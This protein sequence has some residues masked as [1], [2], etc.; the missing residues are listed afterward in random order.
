MGISKVVPAKTSKE[1][2]Q[3]MKHLL[4]DISALE[5]MLD[6]N[7]FEDDITRIGA[8]QEFFLVDKHWRPAPVAPE[9][10]KKLPEKYFT[11]ELAKFNLE[12]NLDPQLFDG[13]CMS[14]ME[15][16][17]RKFG[18]QASDAAKEL[19]CYATTVGIL[20]S[21][22]QSDLNISNISPAPRYAALNEAFN[23]LRGDDWELRI[24]GKDELNYNHG[25]V[26]IEACTTS[27]QLHFQT[28][29]NRYAKLYNI[30][31]AISA[32]VVAVA[33]NSPVLLRKRL[34]HETRISLFQQS[35]DTRNVKTMTRNQEPRVSFGNRWLDDSILEIFREDISRFRTILGIDNYE[36]PFALLDKGEIPDLKALCLHN[37]TVYRWN[38]PCYG[39]SNGK[40]HLRIE[41]RIIPA[42]PTPIDVVANA[43]F[44]FGLLRYFSHTDYDVS[45]VLD[46][47]DAKY[48]FLCAS[49][50]SLNAKIKWFNGANVGIS[51]LIEKE[52]VEMA[53]SGLQAANLDH[54][55]IDRYLDVIRERVER[56]QNGSIW[57]LDSFSNIKKG[58][59]DDNALV[60]ITAKMI[61][62]Q[63]LDQPI[64]TWP[65]LEKKDILKLSENYTTVEQIMT[66]EIYTLREGDLVDFVINLMNWQHLR[67]V[68]VEDQEAKLVGMVSYRNVI[69]FIAQSDKLDLSNL[70]AVGDIMTKDLHTVGPE[71]SI[72]D[73]IHLARTEKISCL[74]VVDGDNKLV[75]LLSD[76]ELI[77]MAESLLVDKLQMT[78]GDG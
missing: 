66:D 71:T 76:H 77:N 9:V 25:N 5:R 6:E 44:Y 49:R 38:R 52:L 16:D 47:D 57:V 14:L 3:F 53:K 34:W 35:I 64:H 61:E 23:Q 2:R 15:R 19:D 31:Q 24:K 74:P 65:L 40:P 7:L 78:T 39:I 17:L 51:E 21:I 54:E 37:G 26:L 20:P 59:S 58:I 50:T 12:C 62:N 29:P 13:K 8:E 70:T 46:F 27:F 73:A 72:I 75:G 10:L 36:D 11:T 48:N 22:R 69:K 42:G 56:H 41:N 55:D 63:K 45:Q 1:R 33:A 67:H 32:P 4:T 43:A 68:L 30:A 60:S 28:S 18:K